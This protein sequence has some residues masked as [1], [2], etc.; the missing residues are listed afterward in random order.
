MFCGERDD[1]RQAHLR[2]S[3][4]KKCV[5]QKYVGPQYHNGLRFFL[6]LND[7]RVLDLD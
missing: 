4:L 3:I 5:F 1:Q 6:A 2:N 7:L